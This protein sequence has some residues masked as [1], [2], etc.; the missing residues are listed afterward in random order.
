MTETPEATT[1]LVTCTRL[2]PCSIHQVRNMQRCGKPATDKDKD[3]SPICPVHRGADA[4]G[5]QARRRAKD[6]YYRHMGLNL[7]KMKFED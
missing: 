4:R 3:G 1:A 5:E 2:L 6:R 7:A